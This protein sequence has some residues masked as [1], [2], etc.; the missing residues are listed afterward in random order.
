MRI[1]LVAPAHVRV[2]REAAGPGG[3]VALLAESLTG[4][5]HEVTVCTSE[6]ADVA[7]RVCHIRLPQPEG[8]GDTR[9][10]R[11]YAVRAIA[12]AQH[13][14][15][16]HSFAGSDLVAQASTASVPVLV[17]LGSTPEPL[18]R[19]MWQSYTGAYVVS[20]WWQA[21]EAR[22]RLPHAR[23][24]GAIYPALAVDDLPYEPEKEE[25]L[26][27]LGPISPAR[28]TDI[29]LAAARRAERPLM[30]TGPVAPGAADFFDQEILPHI[31]G[32]FVR[33]LPAA[34][35]DTRTGLL[36]RARALVL[37]ARA[38][39]PW[40]AAAAE[41]LA[42]GTPVVALDRGPMRELVVHAETGFLAEDIA[43]LV[44]GI[45]RIDTIEPRACRRRAERC[46]D[47]EQVATAY[48]TVYEQV[49]SGAVV[50]QPVHPEFE[51]L[52]PRVLVGA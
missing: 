47:I 3:Q 35:P 49:C 14:D 9:P 43:G 52:D 34:A 38:V 50:P 33:Y 42:M 13:Q 22:E 18:S 7:A 40:E 21:A 39:R 2:S 16:M 32:V 44:S 25:Y 10:A 20:S 1:M 27:A 29:A 11:L 8:D 15:I 17:T 12:A 28:G 4:R 26:L 5:G 36:A 45:E 31:D 37:A 23:P 19:P 51:A 46:W 30:I 24:M 6:P 41:A 48:E